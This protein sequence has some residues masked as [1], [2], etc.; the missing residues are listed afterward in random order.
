MVAMWWGPAEDGRLHAVAS[1][2][3]APAAERGWTET[4]CG[5][6]LPV[7]V[8]LLSNPDGVVCGACHLGA[9]TDLESLDLPALAPF[10]Q[11]ERR[12]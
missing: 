7:D 6:R 2:D 8:E 11:P 1:C 5:W 9:T 12:P 4:L 10:G 3:I